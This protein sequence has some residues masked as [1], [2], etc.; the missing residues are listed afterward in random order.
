MTQQVRLVHQRQPN[1]FEEAKSAAIATLSPT[2]RNQLLE[3]MAA[4]LV[5]S[6]TEEPATREDGDDQDHV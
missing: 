2:Q 6:V 3:L 4:L 1:L 5:E